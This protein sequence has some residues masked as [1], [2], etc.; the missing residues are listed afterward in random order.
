LLCG[1]ILAAPVHAQLIDNSRERVTFDSPEGWAMAWVSASSLMTGFGSVP[2]LEPGAFSASVELGSIPT[3][4]EAQQRVGF[5]GL[6]DEDLNKSPLFGRLRAGLGL[7]AG[8]LLELGWTPPLRIDGARARELFALGLGRTLVERE[9]W[10]LSLRLHGQYGQVQGDITCP[11]RLA[12]NPD[13]SI[14]RYGC[15]EPSDD[16]IR[17]RYH[18]LESNIEWGNRQDLRGHAS[19]GFARFEP[20]VQVNA[21]SAGLISQPQLASSGH[22]PYFA[23]GATQPFGTRWEAAVETL[24]VPLEVERRD[25]ARERDPYWSV[26]VLLRYRWGR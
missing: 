2:G 8:W 11:R 5:G 7:P 16:R 20:E 9:R 13:R 12:G 4:S 3:L 25:S 1:F 26:R 10:R 14:N 23:L 15:V 19:F 24:Y 18:A 22:A 17:M 21:R 6:K